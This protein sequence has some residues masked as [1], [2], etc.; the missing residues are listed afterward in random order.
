MEGP[1]QGGTR[2]RFPPPQKTPAGWTF[3]AQRRDTPGRSR[4]LQDS[5]RPL[6]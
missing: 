6:C 2:G 3:G 1:R 5:L 4:L